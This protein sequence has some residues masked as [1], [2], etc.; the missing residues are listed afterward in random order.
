MRIIKSFR[1]H[2]D[3]N[4]AKNAVETLLTYYEPDATLND[5][6]NNVDK[7][8]DKWEECMRC[9]GEGVVRYDIYKD[10]NDE[11]PCGFK[12]VS[13]TKCKGRRWVRKK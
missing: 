4:T 5:I 8:S 9:K 13:C 7:N 3:L 10:E 11:K 12:L 6:L 2:E 1:Y